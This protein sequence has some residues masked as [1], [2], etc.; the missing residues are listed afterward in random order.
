M[1]TDRDELTSPADILVK[2][3]LKIDEGCVGSFGELDIS[4]NSTGEKRSYFTSL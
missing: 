3:V 4:K 1:G 2:L